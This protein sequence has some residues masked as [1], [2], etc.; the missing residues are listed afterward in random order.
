MN[1]DVTPAPYGTLTR[2]WTHLDAADQD[3]EAR[4]LVGVPRMQARIERPDASTGQHYVQLVEAGR[5]NDE[6]ALAWLATTHRPLLLDR[7]RA[8]FAID[9]QEWGSAAVEILHR[10]VCEANLDEGRWLRSAISQRLHRLMV[11]EVRAQLRQRAREQL[12]DPTA[13]RML[14][15][16]GPAV[17]PDPHLDLAAAIDATCGQLDGATRA[18]LQALLEDRSLASVAAAHD[19][20]AA[21]MRQRVRRVRDRLRPELDVYHRVVA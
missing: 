7:G 6:V 8:L 1:C 17:D 2:R 21:A 11:R 3:R 13:L 16:A 15:T 18:G 12:T 5:A 20:S 10:A 4:R 14:N 9:P 19:L